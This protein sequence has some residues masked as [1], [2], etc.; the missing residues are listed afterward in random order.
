MAKRVYCTYFDHNYL[1]RGLALYHS[2]QRHTPGSRAWVLGLS[3]AC[4]RTLVALDS[5]NLVPRAGESGSGA[6]GSS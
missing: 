6:V 4:Y 2:P 5:A 1:S 3:E